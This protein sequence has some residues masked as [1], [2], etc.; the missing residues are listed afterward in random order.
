MK[1][2]RS[3]SRQSRRPCWSKWCGLIA[4]QATLTLS[5][6]EQASAQPTGAGPWP[7]SSQVDQGLAPGTFESLVNRIET[8]PQF[9]RA[10]A[11]LLVRHGT[12]VGE[13]YFGGTEPTALHDLRSVT[14]SVTSMA[15]GIAIARGEVQPVQTKV[16]DLLPNYAHHLAGRLQQE[17]TLEQVL[18]MQAGL[19]TSSC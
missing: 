14:K 18:T 9:A 12:L 10:R 16:T 5:A 3:R 7:T 4:L 11:L 19:E 2:H 17:L 8:D 15:T 13:A 6:L 1:L